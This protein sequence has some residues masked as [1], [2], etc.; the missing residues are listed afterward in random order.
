MLPKKPVSISLEFAEFTAKQVLGKDEDLIASLTLIKKE[1]EKA[2]DLIQNNLDALVMIAA[3]KLNKIIFV[4]NVSV[5]AQEII[6]YIQQA[7][8][9]QIASIK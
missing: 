2:Q 3:V 7:Y 1:P 6:E 9:E 4:N 8:A 5:A